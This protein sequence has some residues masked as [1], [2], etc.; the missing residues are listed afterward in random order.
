SENESSLNE[1]EASIL[2]L[3][4]K[5]EYTP[6]KAQKL[7]KYDTKTGALIDHLK[8]ES[9]NGVLKC[10]IFRVRDDI[11]RYLCEIIKALLRNVNVYQIDSQSENDRNKTYSDFNSDTGNKILLSSW[12]LSGTGINLPGADEVIA[13][14][15][16]YAA[17]DVQQGF[18]R[19]DRFNST[20]NEISMTVFW[21]ET[22]NQKELV[23]DNYYFYSMLSKWLKSMDDVASKNVFYTKEML[24]ALKKQYKDIIDMYNKMLEAWS[25]KEKVTEEE[26]IDPFFEKNPNFKP[27]YPEIWKHTETSNDELILKT[28]KIKDELVE[29]SK[30]M[31]KLDDSSLE[32]FESGV[33]YNETTFKDEVNKFIDLQSIASTADEAIEETQLF[34]GNLIFMNNIKGFENYFEN[35][36]NEDGINSILADIKKTKCALYVKCIEEKF[37]QIN[38]NLK[39]K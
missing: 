28:D 11:Q 20:F 2:D 10:V 6:E 9:E 3:Y 29:M 16:P 25:D 14:E 12:K 30:I 39:N 13:Y 1:D 24:L 34:K 7:I 37:K 8:K 17:A 18:G 31:E 15:L 35:F 32:K 19:I 26:E 33:F 36:L 5:K 21:A 22:D 27:F 38:K 4:K 23:F